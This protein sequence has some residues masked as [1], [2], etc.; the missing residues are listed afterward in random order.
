MPKVSTITNKPTQAS[1][2]CQEIIQEKAMSITTCDHN[3]GFLGMVLRASNLDP[4]KK[5]NPVAP[6]TDPGPASVNTIGTA[7]QITEDTLL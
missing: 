3:Q 2:N 7:D 1:N 6:P 5:E 4:L